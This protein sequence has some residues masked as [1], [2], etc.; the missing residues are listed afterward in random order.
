MAGL[1]LFR[2]LQFF[3]VEDFLT[4]DAC[5][6][7][8]EAMDAGPSVRATVLKKDAAVHLDEQA[9][10]T[11]R[12]EVS[13]A[14]RSE[15]NAALDAVRPRAASHFNVPLMR[16][17]K[18]QFLM[19]NPGDFFERHTDTDSNGIYGRVVS[20]II[21]LNDGYGGGAL[22]FYGGVENKPLELALP[23]RQGMLVGFRAD[24]IHEVEPL[25]SGTRYTVVSWFG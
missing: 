8:R 1:A 3:V 20:T 21:F 24:W 15:I 11:R 18:P 23:A 16:T 7:M 17:E 22:K 2:A 19:Y 9:R 12:I 14:V 13:D 25:T 6:R 5:T 10:S 4:A